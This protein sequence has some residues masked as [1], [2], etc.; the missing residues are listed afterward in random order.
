MVSVN[1]DDL[2]C[3][4]TDDYLVPR[5]ASH[6]WCWTSQTDCDD[7]AV[8]CWTWDDAYLLGYSHYVYPKLCAE[9]HCWHDCRRRGFRACPVCYAAAAILSSSHAVW[10][11]FARRLF[12]DEWLP[13]ERDNFDVAQPRLLVGVCRNYGNSQ[14]LAL[15]PRNRGEIAKTPPR[16]AQANPLPSALLATVSVVAFLGMGANI[17]RVTNIENTFYTDK[18]SEKRLVEIEKTFKPLSKAA[19]PKI[20]SVTVDVDMHPSRQDA[21][22]KGQYVIENTLDEPVTELWLNMPIPHEEDIHRMDLAQATR[23]KSSDLLTKAEELELYM[24]LY[25]FEPALAPGLSLIHI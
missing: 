6:I 8:L 5:D 1:R 17:F 21:T 3:L 23:V 15:A 10:R 22:F 18:K 2:Y 20:R 7:R 16:C 24:R 14:Y 25:R 11:G 19:L 12:R 13:L 9:P 4:R